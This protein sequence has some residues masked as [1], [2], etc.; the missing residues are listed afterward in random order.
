MERLRPG[1]TLD[2]A[3]LPFEDRL[4]TLGPVVPDDATALRWV[5]IYA[6][7][8]GL[9]ADRARA[10]VHVRAAGEAGDVEPDDPDWAARL[11]RMA[12]ATS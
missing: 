10:W 7:A 9:D 6:E 8:A 11:R 5:A 12:E 2:D 4:R 3:D 1:T